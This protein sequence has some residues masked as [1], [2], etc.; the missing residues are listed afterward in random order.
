M[1]ASRLYAP[2]Y[3]LTI[4]QKPGKGSK[5][6][7]G[8]WSIYGEAEKPGPYGPGTIGMM[9][10]VGWHIRTRVF[11]GKGIIACPKETGV[12]LNYASAYSL[13]YGDINSLAKRYFYVIDTGSYRRYLYQKHQTFS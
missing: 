7:R 8:V 1:L 2:A 12:C 4:D 11:N 5:K 10:A 13:I 6:D 9:R 3:C